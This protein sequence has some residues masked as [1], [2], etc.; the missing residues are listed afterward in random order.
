MTSPDII[1]R[2]NTYTSHKRP[3]G[4]RMEEWLMQGIVDRHHLLYKDIP[5]LL[6]EIQNVKSIT[7]DKRK[8]PALVEGYS[9]AK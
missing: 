8:S 9:F 7:A 4:V 2:Y 1:T 3:D 6:C 5:A